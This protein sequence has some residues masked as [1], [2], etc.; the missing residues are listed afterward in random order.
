MRPFVLFLLL[1]F[2]V[3]FSVQADFYLA[4]DSQLSAIYEEE[5]VLSHEF[6]IESGCHLYYFVSESLSLFFETQGE[7]S[8]TTTTQKL[9]GELDVAADIS[10]RL[11][12]ILIRGGFSS[13]FEGQMDDDTYFD[14]IPEIYISYGELEFTLFTAHKIFIM[15]LQEEIYAYQG[16]IG[17]AVAQDTILHKPSL[18]LGV[19]FTDLDYPFYL[20]GKYDLDWY[21]GTFILLT[22]Y[23]DINYYFKEVPYWEWLWKIDL[24]W[25]VSSRANLT[26]EFAGKYSTYLSDIETG[27]QPKVELDV[28]LSESSFLTF[29]VGGDIFIKRSISND[30]SYLFGSIKFTYLF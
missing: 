20:I 27:I 22:G 16:Q 15:P 25:T 12:N 13:Q 14:I 28:D 30:P 26:F 3:A 24:V 18:G 23:T 1:F 8:F 4:I 11:E 19:D 2:T 7:L 6:A 21:L 5:N 17:I 9:A 29:S 10:F